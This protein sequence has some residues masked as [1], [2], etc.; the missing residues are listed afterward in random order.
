MESMRDNVVIS[1]IPEQGEEDPE[2]KVKK[3]K[4]NT[5]QDCENYKFSSS[6]PS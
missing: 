1:G 6:S 5:I 2:M 3:T 4:Q